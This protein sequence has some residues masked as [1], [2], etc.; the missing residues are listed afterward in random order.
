MKTLLLGLKGDFSKSYD[1]GIQRYMFERYK[2]LR[3]LE[4]NIIKMKINSIKFMS[5]SLGGFSLVM[6]SIAVE[7]F[8]EGVIKLIYRHYLNGRSTPNK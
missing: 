4:K 6:R 3:G 8:M 2:G 5:N 7:L 1:A